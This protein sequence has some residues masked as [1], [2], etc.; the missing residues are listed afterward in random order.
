MLYIEVQGVQSE[1]G[2]D[3]LCSGGGEGHG[4]NEIE[5]SAIL[6]LVPAMSDFEA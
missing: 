5:W 3:I 4:Y 2:D 6:L 1:S